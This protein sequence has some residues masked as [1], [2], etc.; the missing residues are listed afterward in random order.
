MLLCFLVSTFL[1]VFY[2]KCQKTSAFKAE[3][4]WHILDIFGKIPRLLGRGL[5]RFSLFQKDLHFVL[6]LRD[7]YEAQPRKHEI[8]V[9]MKR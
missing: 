1:A 8:H 7:D 4:E 9:C 6:A 5:V 2:Q 3:D